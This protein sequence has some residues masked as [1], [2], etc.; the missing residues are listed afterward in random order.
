[1]TRTTLTG[2]HPFSENEGTESMPMVIRI[3]FASRCSAYNADL[4]RETSHTSNDTELIPQSPPTTRG[5]GTNS[6]CL[7]ERA[8]RLVVVVGAPRPPDEHYRRPDIVECPIQSTH[9]RITDT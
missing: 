1:M 7:D 5:G 9:L 6:K 3:Q 2:S 4:I 8:R